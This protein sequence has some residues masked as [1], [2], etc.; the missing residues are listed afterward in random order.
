MLEIEID[1]QQIQVPDGSTVM[2]AAAKIGSYIPHFCYHKKLSIAANC[3]M[4]LVQ[5]EKAPKPLP[6]CATPVTN[7]MKVWTHSE[8][9]VKAQKGVME[10]LLINH[11]L[12]CPICDQGGECQLQDLAVGYGGSQSRYQ[13]EKR[14]VLNK[15]L[16]SLVATDMT[17]CINC[18]RCVRFTTEI[19]GEMELGQAFRGEHAEIMPFVEKTVDSELS[20]N[21]IDLCPVGALTSKPFRFAARTWELSRRKS[22]SPHDSLGAN[23]IVQTKHDVVKRV[24]PLE[25]EAINEC[26]LSDKDRFSYE[27]LNSA[28]RLQRPQIK[29][30]GEWREVDWQTALE[31]AANGLRGIAQ[32]HGGQGLGALLSPHATVEELYLGQK[33]MRGLGTD[34]VD[35]RLRQTDFRADGRRSGAPW[36]GMPIAGVGELDRLLVIGSFLRKDAPLLAQRVRQ[37]AKRGLQVGV[38]G[39]TAEE[40]L[41]PVRSRMVVPPSGMVSALGQLV[42]ALSEQ[43]SVVVSEAFVSSLPAAVSEEA[44]TLARLVGSGERVAIW[45][46]NLAVQH[47]QAAE[48]E[49]LACEIGRLSGGRAGVIGEA[50]NSVGGYLAGAVPSGTGLNAKGMIDS[51]R[52]GYVLLA[53]EPDLDFADAPRTQAALQSAEIVVSLS[54]FDSPALR[55]SAD[56]LLPIAPFSETSGTFVNCEGRAQSFNAVAKPLG[57]CRPGWKVLRVLGTL[58]GLN[59]FAY[60]DSEAVSKAALGADYTRKLAGGETFH[61]AEAA[62]VTDSGAG[63]ERVADVPIYFADPVVRR[64]APLQKTKDAA[65]PVARLSPAT[66][67]QLGVSSGERVRVGQG[68][69]TVELVA[70]ADETLAAGCVRIAAAHRT[71]AALGALSGRLSVERA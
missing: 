12:D 47:S 70:A 14:V 28:E 27:A 11:P 20:G 23:L 22:V 34:N 16:G 40:W 65:V 67:A 4:C 32:Q 62:S 30:G 56:V 42:R 2:D 6:A 5:V 50:A 29:Q 7:G 17:R 38:V 68:S 49:A 9:A 39:P 19:A 36:L 13:E 26:W 51:P 59:D 46:G 1:G 31:F 55:E 52:K 69:G 54:A 48:L 21:I 41:L 66:L 61:V 8:S 15:N 58:L 57:E 3:R 71:T 24:L 37:A 35:F 44:S 25:N 64:S 45:L 10:F 33:L 43:K 18:T 60:E 53:A 63:L